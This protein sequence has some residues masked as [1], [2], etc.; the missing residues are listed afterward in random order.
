M[1]GGHWILHVAIDPFAT[2]TGFL[3]PNKSPEFEHG[4]FTYDP[5]G[6][7]R[8][9][10]CERRQLIFLLNAM[11]YYWDLAVHGILGQATAPST[12]E[13]IWIMGGRGPFGC[14]TDPGM[15]T[16]PKEFLKF[17]GKLG[18]FKPKKFM[19]ETELILKQADGFNCGLL[20]TLFIWDK[21]DYQSKKCKLVYYFIT[22]YIYKWTLVF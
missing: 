2:L 8:E 14:Y 4:V 21:S 20:C 17:M 6:Q 18:P 5:L 15:V 3:Y 7:P 9:L 19:D 1:K 13:Q 10:G 12:W 16:N 22:Y 11:S